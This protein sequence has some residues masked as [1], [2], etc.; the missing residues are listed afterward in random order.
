MKSKTR[1]LPHRVHRNQTLRNAEHF[2]DHKKGIPEWL[3]N[4]DD[5]YTRHEDESGTD[6]VDSIIILN[7]SKKEI[8]CLDFGGS[9]AEKIIEYLPYY[10]SPDAATQGQQLKNKSV[11]GG[12]GSGGKY[13]AL[14]QFEEC[15][16]INY[17]LG[18]LTVL[19]INKEGEYV[20]RE[21]EEVDFLEAVKETGIKSW[22]YFLKEGK[23]ID[24][25]NKSFF[26][27]IGKDPKE[28]ISLSD[29]RKLMLLLSSISNHPQS[30][31]ALR[32]RKV[33]ILFNGNLIW[34]NMKPIEPEKNQDFGVKEFQIPSKMGKYEFNKYFNSSLKIYLAKEPLTGEKSALNILE[35]DA[36][37]K[38]IAYY[39]MQEFMMDKGISKS[40]IAHIDCP[41]LKEYNR[42]S[43]DRFHL[44]PGGVTDLF[45]D[46]CK[47]KIQEILDE[48]T[49]REKQNEEKEHLNHLRDFLDE[50]TEEISSLLE[51]ENIIRPTFSKS[52]KENSMVRI[53][54]EEPGFGG[55]GKGGTS[56]G[57]RRRGKEENSNEKSE[58]KK[59]KNRLQIFISGKDKHPATGETYNMNEHH[60]I[61]DQR[62]IDI[63]YGIWWINSQKRYLKKINIKSKSSY[64]FYFFLIKEIVMCHKL[65]RLEKEQ[66]QLDV[67]SV[68]RLDFDLIDEIFNKVVGRL[69]IDLDTSKTDADRVR[70]CIKGKEKFTI[71]EIAKEANV[72]RLTVHAIVKEKFIQENYNAIKENVPTTRGNKEVNVYVKK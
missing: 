41:E 63:D 70:E 12:H 35:I 7:F 15:K 24:L 52:G 53:K 54:T 44:I 10:G 50:V 4:S 18:K 65:G 49:D 56:G 45:L 20:D 42:V 1:K 59:G 68:V 39:D 58:D 62:S 66:S 34:P 13:Y 21:D 47:S 22:D 16:I 46:W 33:D 36:G 27:W 48:L 9:R 14:S 43:E 29:R 25:E 23:E 28:K 31:S 71:K 51:E 6:L 69:N 37:G 72:N 5:S 67:D 3:K 11:S 57:D 19:R 38:N 61:L 8:C 32:S 2:Y 30:R 26:C 60:P 55:E 64:P 40:L 17:Y